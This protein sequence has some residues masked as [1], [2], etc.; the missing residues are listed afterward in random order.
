M[1]KLSSHSFLSNN[2]TLKNRCGILG[3]SLSSFSNRP[4]NVVATLMTKFQRICNYVM[5]LRHLGYDPDDNE[6]LELLSYGEPKLFSLGFTSLTN[7]TN[8]HIQNPLYNYGYNETP[9]LTNIKE[10]QEWMSDYYNTEEEELPDELDSG[11]DYSLDSYTEPLSYMEY[12]YNAKK[13]RY[14][15]Y[16][17]MKMR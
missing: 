16:K 14:E 3:I 13:R 1:I 12:S 15:Q 10:S 2:D 6:T 4:K 11:E 9:S 5:L 7:H 17:Q 8:K